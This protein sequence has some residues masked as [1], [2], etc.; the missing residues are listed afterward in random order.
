MVICVY[1][2]LFETVVIH[3]FYNDEIYRL[4]HNILFQITALLLGAFIGARFNSLGRILWGIG[5][6]VLLHL[7]ILVN[8]W[9]T[10]DTVEQLEV[11]SDSVHVETYSVHATTLPD[12]I[13]NKVTK[14]YAMFSC[15]D[16]LFRAKDFETYTYDQRGACIE[17]RVVDVENALQTFN[18]CSE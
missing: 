6:M 15:V 11:G 9:S 5:L 18:Y 14:C 12:L 7:F 2:G 17:F 8:L 13:I 4:I 10:T 3:G 1:L 16:V